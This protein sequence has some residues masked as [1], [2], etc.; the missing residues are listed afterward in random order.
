MKKKIFST[1]LLMLMIAALMV[2]T[3]GCNSEEANA[4][5][6]ARIAELEQEN[7]ALRAQLEELTAEIERM[8]QKA[9]LQNWSLDAQTWSD[10]NG[11]TVPCCSRPDYLPSESQLERYRKVISKA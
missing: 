9:S 4:E 5:S 1:M 10:G 2:F 7:T 3:T 6:S 11:A 8:K